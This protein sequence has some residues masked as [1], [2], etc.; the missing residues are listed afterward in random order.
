MLLVIIV[1]KSLSVRELKP[2]FIEQG[3]VV[4]RRPFLWCLMQC[5]TGPPEGYTVSSKN[6]YLMFLPSKYLSIGGKDIGTLKFRE[7]NVLSITN[8]L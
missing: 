1:G 5:R 7:E 6:L 3:S 2:S 8:F 4:Q